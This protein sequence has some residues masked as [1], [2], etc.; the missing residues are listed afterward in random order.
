MRKR[1]VTEFRFKMRF[2]EI[3]YIAPRPTRKNFN[4]TR[5]RGHVSVKKWQNG[6]YM[7]YVSSKV[8]INV[9]KSEVV[10]SPPISVSSLVQSTW[11]HD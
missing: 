9:W 2:G 8:R 7:F 4:Y 3:S 11:N 5:H 6:E 10:I 1:D